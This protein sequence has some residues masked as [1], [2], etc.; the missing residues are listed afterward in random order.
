MTSGPRILVAGAGA[1]GLA[2]A[3]A[4][5]RRGAQV[6]VDDP[7]SFAGN[8]SGV[9]A[10]ML[11]PVFEAAL[12]ALARPHF[13]LLTAA[14]DLWPG[15]AA[16]TGVQVVKAGAVAVGETAWLDETAERLRDLG[17]AFGRLQRAELEAAAPGLAPQ[18]QTG[19][20]TADD[21][22]IEAPA[23]LAVLRR[24]AVGL[25]VAFRPRAATGLDGFDRLVVATG[26]A[27]ELSGLAPELTRMTPIKG[28]ILRAPGSLSVVVRS[29]GVYVAP[30]EGGLAIGASMEAGLE[31]RRIDAGQVG[32]LRAAAARL[33]PALAKAPVTA[34][35]GVRGATPDGLPLAGPSI[36]A[37]VL[38]AAGARRNG[39]LLAPLVAEVVAACAL[40][41][42]PGPWAARLAPG[43]FLS[44]G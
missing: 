1:L 23:A 44:P 10:G 30:A 20:S 36:A 21:W 13:D 12:D 40:E 25:G 35:A 42:D 15:F 17:A 33:F 7:G 26:A 4:L 16:A 18:F 34:A 29:Q 27:R 5:A 6:T 24:A 2:T 43:R 9:A 11:A 37:G 19:L 31:D 41:R 28:H 3:L 32:R 14:R 39:W 38:I 8:A 22:R